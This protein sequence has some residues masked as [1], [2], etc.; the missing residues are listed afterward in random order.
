MGPSVQSADL[1]GFADWVE[2]HRSEISEGEAHTM[3][4]W[5]TEL[6]LGAEV[7][8]ASAFAVLDELLKT[9]RAERASR[10]TRRGS[11]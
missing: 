9:M 4:C 1:P 8:R 10:M 5:N 3:G 11:P 2:L 6:V 7:T